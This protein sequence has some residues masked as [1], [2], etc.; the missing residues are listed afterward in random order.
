MKLNRFVAVAA[1]ALL[2]V[3]AMGAVTS[4][5][6][7][8]TRSTAPT[9]QAAEEAEAAPEAPPAGKAAITA[10]AARKAAEA[11]LNA[12]AASEV[13]LENENGRLVYS[14]EIGGTEV[15]VDAMTGEVLGPGSTED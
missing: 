13:E 15:D 1:T 3:G 8:Q 10:E 11:Y 9:P 6:L 12:G 14:V 2:F 5:A 4:F 7:A